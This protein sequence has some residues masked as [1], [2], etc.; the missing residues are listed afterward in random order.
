[1]SLAELND[2]DLDGA[3]ATFMACCGARA[4][5]EAMRD[6]RPFETPKALFDAADAAFD[7]L[8]DEDWLEAFAHHPRIGDVDKLRAR[9]G[10][11]GDHSSREQAGMAGAGDAVIQ[12]LHQGNLDY[13]ARFGHVFLI[14]ATGK[15]AD[16]ML[17]SLSTRMAN[18]PEQELAIAA[19]EQRQITRLR[20]ARILV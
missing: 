19:N 8:T 7:A 11:S 6:A 1:M 17:V 12:S 18:T 9:F 20:L 10:R 4:W 3:S 15:T 13:E 16:E 5:A 14:C 2:D